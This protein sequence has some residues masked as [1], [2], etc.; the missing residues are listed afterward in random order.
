M[1]TLSNLE[2]SG[3]AAKI[4]AK[5]TKIEEGYYIKDNATSP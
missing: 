4:K 1:K 3:Y 5:R 2:D